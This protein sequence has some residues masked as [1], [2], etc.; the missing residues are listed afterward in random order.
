MRRLSIGEKFSRIFIIGNGCV[1]VLLLERRIWLE[2]NS[3]GSKKI[4]FY[5]K[6][7]NDLFTELLKKNIEQRHMTYEIL[8]F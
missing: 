7:L 6:S 5:L 3:L 1:C 8:K 2:T 4:S